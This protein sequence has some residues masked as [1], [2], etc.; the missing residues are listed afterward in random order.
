MQR[1]PKKKLIAEVIFS[2]FVIRKDKAVTEMH[3]I[4]ALPRNFLSVNFQGGIYYRNIT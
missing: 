1:V 4:S 3:G 2:T